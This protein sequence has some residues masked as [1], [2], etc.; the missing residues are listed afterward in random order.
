[1]F[2]NFRKTTYRYQPMHDANEDYP[3]FIGVETSNNNQEQALRTYCSDIGLYFEVSGINAT[4]KHFEIQV[5]NSRQEQGLETFVNNYNDSSLNDVNIEDATPRNIKENEQEETFSFEIIDDGKVTTL[6]DV[7]MPK[8]ASEVV[9]FS[10]KTEGGEYI[11][12]IKNL[13]KLIDKGEM[14]EGEIKIDRNKGYDVK[15]LSTLIASY[16]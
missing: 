16:F 3:K 8:S 2:N 1:M 15:T 13:N 11:K 9:S 14:A 5:K 4:Q 6:F 7:I 12:P 10:W